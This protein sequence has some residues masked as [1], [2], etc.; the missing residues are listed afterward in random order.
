MDTADLL[1]ALDAGETI[2]GGSPLH[3]VMHRTSQE[4]L[5]ITA[6]INGSYHE[7]D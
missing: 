4:A 2:T 6:V 7:P 3:E 1:K 5:C